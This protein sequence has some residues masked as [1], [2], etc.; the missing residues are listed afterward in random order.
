MDTHESVGVND[1]ESGSMNTDPQIDEDQADKIIFWLN[2]CEDQFLGRPDKPKSHKYVWRSCWVGQAIFST[3]EESRTEIEFLYSSDG[4][5]AIM[6]KIFSFAAL[7]TEEIPKP[8]AIIM[9][10]CAEAGT[11]DHYTGN[12]ETIEDSILMAVLDFLK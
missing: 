3:S 6:K 5:M 11:V 4:Q 8:E 2:I 12:G 9:P 1:Y 7:H 10:F